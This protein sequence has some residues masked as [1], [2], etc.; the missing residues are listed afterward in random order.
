MVENWLAGLKIIADLHLL[1]YLVGGVILGNIFGAIPGLT[2]TLAVVLLIPITYGMTPAMGLS[3]LIAAYVGG[4]SGGLVSAT[5][6]GMPGTPSSIA[7]TFDAF[8]MAKKG[9]AGKALGIGISASL[10]GG[11]ISWVI[12]VL[13]SPQLARVALS[14]SAFE[15]TAIYTF[16]ITVVVS[17]SRKS[18]IKG[19]IGA[20]FGLGLAT[21]GMDPIGGVMRT[22]FGSPILE[23]G[24]G[25]F[26]VL[27]GFFVV[28]QALTELEDIKQLYV[29]DTQGKHM[30]D[31]WP[32]FSFL[33]KSLIN[34]LRSSFIGVFIGILPGIGGALAN[35]VAYDQAK[36]ASK[37]PDSF[38]EGNPEGVIA[39]E[40]GN[41]ATIGGALIPMMTLGIP[42]DAATAALLGG[43]TLHGLQPGPLLFRDHAGLVYSVFI[44]FFVANIVMFLFMM[45]F[46]IKIYT[47]VLRIPK[48]VLMPLIV[49][50]C[51]AG[52]YN[53]NYRVFNIW[54][55]LIF[56]VIGYF[57]KKNNYPLIP[58]IIGLIL[59]PMFERDLRIALMQSGGSYMPFLTRPISLILLILA[60][61]SFIIGIYVKK[62]NSKKEGILL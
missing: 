43:I 57:L 61:V 28:S 12:L 25:F 31:F 2:A 47:R 4:M 58:I 53:L 41:N 10:I 6:I 16:G 15:Y 18:L 27:I 11:M 33:R 56:G 19:L 55:T 39:S 54:L 59:G 49:T 17:L 22:V 7:T 21:I 37:N 42:G 24:I 45:L 29:F 20:A 62:S 26:P 50:M 8:P 60:M 5:L 40:S 51:V 48:Y 38:G 32:S 46:G 13:L 3:T 35:L 9:Y 14:F 44:A 23:A 1:L 30:R 36:K 34:L 52:A